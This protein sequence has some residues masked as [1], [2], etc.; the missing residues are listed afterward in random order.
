[1]VSCRGLRIATLIGLLA[2]LL[3]AAPARAAAPPLVGIGEQSPEM[4]SDAK[5][6]ALGLKDLRVIAS[7]DALHSSW[8]RAALDAY[9]AGARAAGAR[10]LLGF[11]HSRIAG[12]E[13]FL[14]TVATFKR[15]FLRFRARYPWVKD[16]LTWNEA[17]H[18]S[19]P[20]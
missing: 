12:H 2:A 10:V 7:Y 5:W 13:H 1:P 15:E 8:Q 20:T 4:F 17:N 9:M 6:Q 18:C 3:L 16:Y 11:G 14:P 19:Q